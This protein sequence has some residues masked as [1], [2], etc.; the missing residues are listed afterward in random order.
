MWMTSILERIKKL[1][2][3]KRGGAFDGVFVCGFLIIVALGMVI[4]VES[5]QPQ[6]IA[7]AKKN[8]DENSRQNTKIF[9]FTAP[10]KYTTIQ[11]DAKKQISDY[12]EERGWVSINQDDE[13]AIVF[14]RKE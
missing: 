2:C 1:A 6:I 7:E 9:K 14:H 5:A 8:I 3:N 11:S 12:A 13:N 10:S 4:K